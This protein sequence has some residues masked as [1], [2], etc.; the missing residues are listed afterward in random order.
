MYTYMYMYVSVYMYARVRTF[1]LKQPN[2]YLNFTFLLLNIYINNRLVLWHIYHCRL[3]KAKSF[4]FSD[5]SPR[6]NI[7]QWNFQICPVGWGCR[8]HRLYLCRDSPPPPTSVLNT[9]LNYL[10]VRLQYFWSFRECR[11]PLYCHRSQVH[12]C[13]EW[14]HLI[15]SYQWVK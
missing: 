1:C 5:I 10:M 2:I 9:T 8:I 4:L 13:P 15:E 7:V 6:L 12:F 14:Q 11:V 3:F